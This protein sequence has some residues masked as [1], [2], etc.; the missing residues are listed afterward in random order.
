MLAVLDVLA[1]MGAGVTAGVLFCVALSIVPAFAALPADR[2][3]ELHRLVGRNY[4]PTMPILVLGTTL[5]AAARAVLTPGWPARLPFAVAALLLLAV[6]V[7]SHLGNV[8]INRLV[9]RPGR[10][11]APA[12]VDRLRRRWRH[13]HLL[14]TGLALLALTCE[15]AA[16]VASHHP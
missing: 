11:P 8:P 5:A 6:S 3:I 13:L 1:L 12:H 16:V 15:A 7:V 14:R 9:K 10:D 2:Y 4:D